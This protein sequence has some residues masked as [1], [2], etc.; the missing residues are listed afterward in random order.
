VDRVE[1]QE[2]TSDGRFGGLCEDGFVYN[3]EVKQYHTYVANGL[4]VHNCHHAPSNSYKKIIDYFSSAKILGVT[5]TPDRADE[6]AMGQVF[7]SVAFL[8]EIEDAIRDGYLC[9]VTCSRI[10]IAG[11]DLSSVKTTAGDLNQGELDKVMAIEEVLL[12]VADATIREAGKRQT[13]VFTTSVANAERLAEIMNRYRPK[14]DPIAM[15]VNGKTET[16]IRRDRL[17][18]FQRGEFQFLVNVQIATEG[19]DCPTAA[20]IAMARPTKSRSLYAQCV[21][22]GLRPHLS[23]PDGCIAEGQ[24]VLT[25]IGLVR[26]E[27]VTTAM[28][29]WDGVDFVDHG[30]AILRGEREVITYA[31]LTATP[32]HEVWTQEGWKAIGEC[33]EQQVSISITGHGRIPVR[34]AS[35]H[36]RRGVESRERKPSVPDGEMLGMWDREA[37]GPLQLGERN[38]PHEDEPSRAKSACLSPEASGSELF[39]RD[40]ATTRGA[41]DRGRDAGSLEGKFEEKVQTRVW[42]ILNAGPLRRFTVEGLLVHNCLILDFVG[43]SGRHQLSSALDILG[44]KYTEDE[45]EI[46]QELVKKNPGMKA[47]D[48][49]D[50]AHAQAERLK[51]ETEEAAKRAAIKAKA[52]YTKSTV[53]PFG[54]FHMDVEREMA[55]SDRFGGRPPSEKQLACLE[56]AKIPIPAGCT[57]QLASKL[58]GTM[59]K[60]R[61]EHLAT[62]GQLKTLQKYGVNDVNVSFDTASSIITAI[63]VNGWK[64]LPFAK[65]DALLAK[66]NPHHPF[67][68]EHS[69]SLD[70]VASA[71]SQSPGELAMLDKVFDDF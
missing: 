40:A 25:D 71:P 35:G 56:R 4:I 57:A 36:F 21:G 15:D 55:I 13:V 8:Y 24:R 68:T 6:K 64:P 12:G 20:C 23:K 16:L 3:F 51:R 48:A 53:N 27:D 22:R 47:R 10:E 14:N 28:K 43:N 65:L 60:R 67:K 18:R 61:A 37:N 1:V 41:H 58:I 70:T 30:G 45:E 26:I 50:Q 49:L 11:L 62:F 7:D 38:C 39:R 34:E 31:G 69:V 32:D 46:A 9:E 42:D 59:I 52:I 63:N 33:S 44:G 66:G 54:V 29:V 2:Q 17:E 5:A 19:W